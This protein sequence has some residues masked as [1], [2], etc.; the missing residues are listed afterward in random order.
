MVFITIHLNH[1]LGFDKVSNLNVFLDHTVPDK[2]TCA[3]QCSP[4]E[5]FTAPAC[6]S[7]LPHQKHL[8]LTSD[9]R[10]TGSYNS[11]HTVWLQNPSFSSPYLPQEERAWIINGVKTK[12]KRVQQ[13]KRRA[14]EFSQAVILS[15]TRHLFSQLAFRSQWL[16][17]GSEV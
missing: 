7:S 3:K 6:A 1:D 13:R 10:S 2:K 15:F 8:H 17:G 9:L 4:D 12:C 5:S 14:W 16:A 11:H